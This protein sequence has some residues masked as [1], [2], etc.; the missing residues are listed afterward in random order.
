MSS[1]SICNKKAVESIDDTGVTETVK[2]VLGKEEKEKKIDKEDSLEK[3][4]ANIEK[5]INTFGGSG[6]TS[7]NTKLHLLKILVIILIKNL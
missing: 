6:G 5:V 3:K 1:N 7:V 4:L 2:D